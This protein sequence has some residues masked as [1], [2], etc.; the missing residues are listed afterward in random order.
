VTIS[1]APV[2]GPGRVETPDTGVDV[3]TGAF[4]DSGRAIARE[5]LASGRA[6]RTITGHPERAP[7]DSRI[8]VRPFEFDDPVRLVESMEGATTLYDTY[9]IRFAHDRRDHDQA[10]AD[11][12]ALFGAARRAGIRRI[13][14]VSITHPSIDSPF[15]YFRGKAH[16]L[17]RLCV[18][19]GAEHDDSVIDAVGPD[20]PTFLE[21]VTAVRRVVGSTARIVRVPG[22]VVPALSRALGV[23][24][25]DVLLT[26]DEYRAMAAGLADGEGPATAP[27]A[28]SEW[29]AS[30]GDTLGLRY[31]N[32]LH[33]HFAGRNP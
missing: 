5:L 16:D 29:L 7:G 4:S 11:S 10:V 2:I 32:E 31:A 8:D 14:H 27:A 25:R 9:W 18:T 3:V 6:V 17:A 21:L 15:P 1:A 33:R 23:A 20:R 12:R 28:I 19:K 22:P 30:R 26:G 24:L 13:V